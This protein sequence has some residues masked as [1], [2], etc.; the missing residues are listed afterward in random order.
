LNA[1]PFQ[2]PVRVY[3]EDTDAAG[4][5]YHA[6]Y[7]RFMERAR[8]EW[9]RSRGLE[10]TRLERE[11]GVVFVVSRID[12]RYRRPARLDDA[13]AV[14]ADVSQ[15]GRASFHMSQRV[16]R[17]GDLLCTAELRVGCLDSTSLRPRALPPVLIPELR[18]ED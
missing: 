10:P 2:W 14:E 1:G 5:V 13:L 16:L 12:V 4:I 11:D 17:G 6:S 3:Y 7:L 15:V 8:T 9:L 18:R